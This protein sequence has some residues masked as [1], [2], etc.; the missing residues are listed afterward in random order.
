MATS[1]LLDLNATLGS[2]NEDGDFDEDGEDEGAQDGAPNGRMDDSSE[3][4][5]DDDDEEE[6]AKIREGFIV[7]EEEDD[8]ERKARRREKRKRRREEREEEGLD[9]EDLDLIGELEPAGQQESKHK[10]LKRGHRQDHERG[11]ADIFDDD[12]DDQFARPGDELDDFIEEDEFPDEERDRAQEELEVSRKPRRGFGGQSGLQL[13]GLDEA[14]MEDMRAAFGDGT[15]YDWAL[16]AQEQNDEELD[17]DKQLELKD[18]FEP[19]Q[20]AE[21]MLTEEDNIIRS[22]DIPERFQLAR[23]PFKELDL[24]EEEQRTRIQDEAQW[25]THFMWPKKMR[26]LDREFQVPFQ[27]SIASVLE[28]ACIENFEV[29]FI[30][31]HRKDYLIHA[32][33]VPSSPTADGAEGEK[34]EVHAK[35]LLD[36]SDL[37]EIMDFDL[38]YRALSEKRESLQ[39]SYDGIKEM[40]NVRDDAVEDMLPSA[41]T[42]EE[43]QDVQDYVQFQYSAELKDL[44]V[45]RADPGTIKRAGGD[46]V[47]WESIRQGKAYNVVRGFGVTAEQF[48]KTLLEDSTRGYTDDPQDQPDDMA[49]QNTDEKFHTGAQVLRAS[50]AMFAEELVM[51]PRMR[52]FVRQNYFM[53]GVF[54]CV[55][56]EKGLRKIDEDH[57]YYEFKYLRNQSL[58]A[59][60][61]RPEL[62]LRMLKAQE[63]G[64]ITVQLRMENKDSFRRRLQ[65]TLE[66]DNFSEV[67]DAWNKLRR[68]VLDI[69]LTKLEKIMVKSVTENLR[70]ECESQ[71][72]RLCREKYAERLDQ[73]PYKP[74]GMIAGQTPRVLTLTNGKGS[75][76]RDDIFWAYLEDD[77][78][79][80]EHGKL[81]NLRLGNTEKALP[82]GK[83]VID[84]VEIVRRRKPDVLGVSGFSPE[85][86]LLY[87]DLQAIIAEFNLEGAE[88]EDK[89]EVEKRDPLEVIIVNDEV[90]RLYHTSDRSTIDHPGLSPL[91]KYCIALGRYLQSPILEYASLGKDVGFIIFDPNQTLIPHEKLLKTLDTAMV[92]MVNLVGVD[93]NEAV[94]NTYIANLLPFVCGLGPRKAHAMLQAINRNGG[95]VSSREEL[96]GDAELGKIQA[97]SAIVFQNCSSFLY[98]EYD[99][100]ETGANYLDNTRIH[101]EDYDLARKMAADAL[102]LDEEDIEAEQDEYGKYAIIRKLVKEDNQERVNDLILEEYAEQLEIHFNSRKR[103]TLET[104][105]AE[106]NTPYEELRHE[107]AELTTDE[108][109]TMLTGETKDSL[110]EN[111]IVPISIRRVFPDHIEARLDCG[112]EAGISEPEY[113][114]LDGRDAKHVFSS[115]QVIQAKLV[116]LNRRQL[117]AQLTLR[118]DAMRRPYR[119][120][121]DHDPGEWDEDQEEADQRAAVQRK[122]QITGR[123]Q[124]VIKHPL[125]RP[126]NSKQ[127]EEFLGPQARGE[128][129]IRPSSKGL[130]HLAVTWKVADQ[131]FQHIDVLELDKE[132]EFSVGRTLKIGR[133][134]YSD[135]DEL[136]QTHVKAMA[137]KVDEICADERFK[138]GG[139]QATGKQPPF[140]PFVSSHPSKCNLLTTATR[141]VAHGLHV[142]Q[143]APLHVRLLPAAL[144]PGLL[145]AV[146]QGRRKGQARGVERQGRAQ[147]VRAARPALR[148]H[149]P[150][151]ERLQDALRARTGRRFW[152]RRRRC[153]CWCSGGPRRDAGEWG[154]E[155]ARRTCGGWAPALLERVALRSSGRQRRRWELVYL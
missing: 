96:I 76:S 45:S 48:A 66:S 56:S 115:H 34:Y 47:I 27:K 24:G 87:K 38:K 65:K 19:S 5:D 71:V 75:A 23:Q 140:L 52:K 62:Y 146:L 35:K 25:I 60:A 139:R 99:P 124:R 61:R 126:F 121:V 127:A 144:A 151:Q 86:R 132:N 111:M 92:D 84:L 103:A 80:L 6:A 57:P 10:R 101:P 2:E 30:F 93:I 91:I 153:W 105:R 119:K 123:A 136:I 17:P 120:E 70:A 147:R 83:G 8:E 128:C 78:R 149:A 20:L 68:E 154:D 40:A 43:V 113:P 125:F 69:A 143:P 21:K 74:K 7:D 141:G 107:F 58:A 148:R 28:F 31:Q 133:Y 102:E 50:K 95:L 32:A 138:E 81:N 152:R 106:I 108:I 100:T 51:S 131:V 130:D 88:Y 155:C 134:T 114:D 64:L 79:V 13:S 9:D 98:I 77:G 22:T 73:M 29:P 67:A 109:F 15:E 90:A 63:E 118:E 37:W 4:E 112:I 137:K 116:F 89:D 117:T 3:E 110:V 85:T 142:R 55:R 145:P 104:I 42:M 49:D 135:L 16:E 97:V 72:A 59:I 36:Q 44:K 41:I 11:V 14:G 129:V 46:S 12:D 82:N 1:D 39:S 18:V 150:A 54:D 94:S 53:Q 122:E 26:D 33:K